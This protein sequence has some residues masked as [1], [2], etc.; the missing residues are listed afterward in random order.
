LSFLAAAFGFA[1]V[2]S[3]LRSIRG[4]LFRQPAKSAHSFSSDFV[5]AIEGS[6]WLACVLGIFAAAPHPVTLV[7]L[8]LLIASVFTAR[9]LRYHE[10]VRSLNDWVRTGVN[11]GASIPG[12]VENLADGCRS[13]LARRAKAFVFRI[14]RGESIVDAARKSKLPLDANTLAL[15]AIPDHSN[16]FSAATTNS[17]TLNSAALDSTDERSW[18]EMPS[19]T[20]STVPQQFLYVVTTILLAWFIGMFI[21]GNVILML[22][23]M[24]D[25]FSLTSDRPR[26]IVE[27]AG[28]AGNVTVFL[29]VVWLILA[30][31][32]RWMP[33][34]VLWCIPW[35]GRR[36]IDRGRSEVLGT[37]A[38]GVRAGQPAAE[39]LRFSQTSTRIRWVR[40]RCRRALGMVENGVSLPTAMQSVNLIS[41]QEQTWLSSAQANGNLAGAL[42]QL[43]HNITRRQSLLWRL[44]M[45]WFV[46]LGTVAVGTY[47]LVHAGFVF[48]ILFSFLVRNA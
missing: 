19:T 2:A 43:L 10:E 45:A 27:W 15:I 41:A 38:R 9:K 34:R 6:L 16:A 46:P 21:R 1:L 18:S 17:A 14:N 37:L 47:V 3:T 25:E 26:Q 31:D 13:G 5:E 44:R 48:H 35:F 23:R 33:Y 39:I 12:L 36:A 24:G 42:E 28:T 32:S 30:I 29:L 7:L 4:N 8:V 11:T 40:K 22:N 20:E